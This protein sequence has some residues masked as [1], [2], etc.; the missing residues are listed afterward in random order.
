[1]KALHTY[2]TLPASACHPYTPPPTNHTKN[3]KLAMHRYLDVKKK[4]RSGENETEQ[5]L[6]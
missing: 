3:D 2:T 1:M 5:V 6:Y 4:K